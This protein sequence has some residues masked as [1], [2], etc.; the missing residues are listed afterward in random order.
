MRARR[1]I[2]IQEHE[3][4]GTIEVYLEEYVFMPGIKPEPWFAWQRIGLAE[5]ICRNKEEVRIAIIEMTEW[6]DV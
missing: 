4:L 2:I 3:V 6:P 5:R 1:R